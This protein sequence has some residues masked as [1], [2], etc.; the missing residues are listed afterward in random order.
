MVSSFINCKAHSNKSILHLKIEHFCVRLRSIMC[1]KK[2]KIT[3]VP[4]K[5]SNSKPQPAPDSFDQ[6]LGLGQDLIQEN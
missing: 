6:K 1:K 4:I 2:L 3:Q 5:T